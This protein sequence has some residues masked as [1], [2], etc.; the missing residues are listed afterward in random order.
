M[1]PRALMATLVVFF[2]TFALAGAAEQPF[3]HAEADAL[4]GTHVVF[5]EAAHGKPTIFILAVDQAASENLHEWE[6]MFASA[7]PAPSVR[8]VS[9][10][11]VVGAPFFVKGAIRKAIARDAP[12]DRSATLLTFSGNGWSSLVRPGAKDALGIVVLDAVGNVV[13]DERSTPSGE[14][15]ARALAIARKDP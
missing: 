2:A 3:P 1:N 8:V 7:H 12:A 14:V 9:V 15:L 5:P 10:V 4:D 13:F 11:V 6:R